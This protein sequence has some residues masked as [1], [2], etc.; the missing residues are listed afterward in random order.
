[1]STG[2]MLPA[3]RRVALSLAA[4]ETGAAA[5]FVLE[6]RQ[7]KTCASF[8]RIE[9]TANKRHKRPIKRTDERRKISSDE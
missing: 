7:L 8:S 9:A 3:G 1:M 4:C 6:P 2:L 5:W